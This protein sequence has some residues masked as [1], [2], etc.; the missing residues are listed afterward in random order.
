M[1]GKQTAILTGAALL[2]AVA[3]GVTA[4]LRGDS[5]VD[6][7][8]K[9]VKPIADARA[10]GE[11]PDF[12]IYKA[13]RTDGGAQYYGVS[14]TDA[15]CVATGKTTTCF[16]A[17]TKVVFVDGSPCR[18]QRA[19]AGPASCARR[20]PDGGERDFGDENVMQAGQWVD[21]GGCEEAPCAVFFGDAP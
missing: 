17:L 9:D 11:A 15:G 5:K 8:A 1:N 3:L 13:A 18:R 6:P 10:A 12:A 2:A 21:H 7:D 16:E 19:K 14:K 20:L 4:A